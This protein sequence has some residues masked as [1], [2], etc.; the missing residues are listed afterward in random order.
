V[1]Q[2]RVETLRKAFMDTMNDKD[3]LADAEKAQLEI[4]P[5]SGDKVQALVQEIYQTPPEIAKKAAG[6][7]QVK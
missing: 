7:L 2:D 6:L 3:F 5:V 4:T 1:P